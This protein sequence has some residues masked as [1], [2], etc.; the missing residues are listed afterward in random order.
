MHMLGSLN[1]LIQSEAVC[2]V[3]ESKSDP[4]LLTSCCK[5]V[6]TAVATMR[7]SFGTGQI[8]LLGSLGKIAICNNVTGREGSVCFAMDCLYFF[9]K[10]PRSNLKS[11][12]VVL[13]LL[14]FSFTFVADYGGFQHWHVQHH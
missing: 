3:T 11:F 8:Q 7:S 6:K 9:L 12:H 1:A 14:K 5:F 10:S 2:E 4:S 13:V